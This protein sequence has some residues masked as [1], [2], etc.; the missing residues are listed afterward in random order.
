MLD[1]KSYSIV[2]QSRHVWTYFLYT[3]PSILISREKKALAR[4]HGQV[5]PDR[6]TENHERERV[7][8]KKVENTNIFI[9][10]WERASSDIVMTNRHTRDV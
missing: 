6:I 3:S 2:H 7:A 10:E 9:G 4:D 8:W 5:I 1:V